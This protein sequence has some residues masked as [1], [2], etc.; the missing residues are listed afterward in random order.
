MGLIDDLREFNSNKP[1]DVAKAIEK[2]V[3]IARSGKHEDLGLAKTRAEAKAAKHLMKACAKLAKGFS[4]AAELTFRKYLAECLEG[5]D[6]LNTLI[7]A[8]EYVMAADFYDR[9]ADYAY[10]VLDEFRSYA[11]R[12]PISVWFF[13]DVRPEE[14]MYDHRRGR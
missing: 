7:A 5:V 6:D 2:L 11:W 3:A 14:L 10:D 1:E 13:D 12:H 9:E 4:E 8:R